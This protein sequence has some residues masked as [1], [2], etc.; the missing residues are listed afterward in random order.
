MKK[1]IGGGAFLAGL[2]VLVIAATALATPGS[3]VTSTA[4]GQGTLKPIDVKVKTGAWKLH[5][6]TKGLSE[7]AVSE[8]RIAPGG[9]S[10]WHSHPGPSL[11]VVKSGTNTFY[12]GDDPTCT[13]Q[14]Y[15]AR[16]AFV[17]P[18]GVVHIARNEGSEEL[19][20]LTTR[21]IP[22]GATPRI[23][24]PDPGNCNF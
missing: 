1:L 19:V 24:E 17:D 12:R 5:V 8:L 11:V 21:L 4:L 22:S 13:P 23:D 16:S 14:V 7:L 2:S 3:R 15:E 20:L 6:K 9:H 10:G 18:G